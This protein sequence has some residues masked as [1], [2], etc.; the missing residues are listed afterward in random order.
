M[1]NKFENHGNYFSLPV[2]NTTSKRGQSLYWQVFI[3]LVTS[4]TPKEF[5]SGMDPSDL[6]VLS[7]PIL[8]TYY[9]GSRMDQKIKGYKIT[10]TWGDKRDAKLK[11]A[12]FITKGKNENKENRTNVWTQTIKEAISDYNKK[13]KPNEKHELLTPMLASGDAILEDNL[14]EEISKIWSKHPDDIRTQPKFDGHRLLV[15]MTR[16]SE[17]RIYPYSRSGDVSHISN[18][19]MAE[20]EFMYKTIFTKVGASPDDIVYLDGEYY[21]HGLPLQAISSAVRSEAQ[22]EIKSTLQYHIFDVVITSEDGV[23]SNDD[24]RTRLWKVHSLSTMFKLNLVKFVESKKPIGSQDMLQDYLQKRKDN[25]EGII[26]RVSSKK[27]ES[28]RTPNMIKVKSL[29]REEFRIIGFSEGSGKHAGLIV[30]KC[31]LTEQSIERARKYMND[32]D[33]PVTEFNLE[34]PKSVQFSVNPKATEA[35]RKKMFEEGSI[36]IGKLYTV[37]FQD[38]SKEFKPLRPIGIAIYEP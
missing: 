16:N 24:S 1:D 22:T 36:Y 28:G 14:A 31:S 15:K 37:E 13:N 34:N 2:I 29:F 27:Y 17:T 10:A 6:T 18:E 26:V 25:Y 21:L 12:T 35:E 7:Q 23:I 19:L 33:I 30:F 32:K 8:G 4:D 3:G 5:A 20:L 11:T 38:W 9:D